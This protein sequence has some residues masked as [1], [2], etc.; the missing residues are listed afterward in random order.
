MVLDAVKNNGWS[1]EYASKRLKKDK[2][3]LVEAIIQESEAVNY[4]PKS[5]KNNKDFLLAIEGRKNDISNELKNWYQEKMEILANI[6]NQED[7]ELIE[8]AIFPSSL[9]SK[10]IKF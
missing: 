8:K 9:K 2:V 7:K 6:R 3:I 1:L 4:I 5:M 10:K